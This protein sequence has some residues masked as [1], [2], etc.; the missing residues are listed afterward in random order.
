LV[1]KVKVVAD[2]AITYL[3]LVE[4]SFAALDLICAFFAKFLLENI[5]SSDY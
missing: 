2:F 4:K 1:N 3:E 5:G